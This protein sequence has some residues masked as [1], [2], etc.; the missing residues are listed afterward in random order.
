M[1]FSQSIAG[2]LAITPITLRCRENSTLCFVCLDIGPR[3]LD[4]I[5]GFIYCGI[6]NPVF[7]QCGHTEGMAHVGL[8]SLY[9]TS[10]S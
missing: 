1:W 2:G 10:L 7:G 9:L 5:V 6:Q 3:F 8:F 4:L